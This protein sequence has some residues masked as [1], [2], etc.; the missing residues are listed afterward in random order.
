[1]KEIVRNGICR[2]CYKRLFNIKLYAR[3]CKC[4]YYKNTCP[5]C[6]EEHHLV[7]SLKWHIRLRL[8]FKREPDIANENKD[9]IVNL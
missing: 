7:A 2:D 5:V 6:K 3:D 8:L 9:G 1:M 4:D